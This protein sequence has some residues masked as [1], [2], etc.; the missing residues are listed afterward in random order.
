MN[1][2]RLSKTGVIILALVI[3]LIIFIA[4]A[5]VSKKEEQNKEGGALARLRKRWQ[6]LQ[7]EIQTEMDEL[8]LTREMEALL[9]QKI[10]RMFLIGKAIFI[11]VFATITVGYYLNGL[12]IITSLL[13]SAGTTQTKWLMLVVI[14]SEE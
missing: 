13:S 8:K 3:L 5:A 6:T 9:E 1:T 4:I 7:R 2:I 11:L 10:N 14:S 12:D